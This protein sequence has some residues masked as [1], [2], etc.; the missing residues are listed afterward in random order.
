LER[1][2]VRADEIR[3]GR[4]GGGEEGEAR[5]SLRGK[6]GAIYKVTG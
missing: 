6:I 3:C 4:R 2:R 1:L 5:D